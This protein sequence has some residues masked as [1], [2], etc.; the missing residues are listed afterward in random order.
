MKKLFCLLLLLL[1]SFLLPG[2]ASYK[3]YKVL[4]SIKKEIPNDNF[5]FVER[6][7]LR[8]NIFDGSSY[9]GIIYS[10]ALKKEKSTSGITVWANTQGVDFKKSYRHKLSSLKNGNIIKDK[11]K[12][13]FQNPLNTTVSGSSISIDIFVDDLANVDIDEIKVKGAKLH[14][15]VL[16]E[17][18][19]NS[20]I[21]ISIQNQK[22]I[23]Y[24]VIKDSISIFFRNDKKL[25][26]I[27]NK[28]KK[29]RI[30][31]SDDE[32]RYLANSFYGSYDE[33]S[34][35]D[36]SLNRRHYRKNKSSLVSMTISAET[37][38]EYKLWIRGHQFNKNHEI[39][40]HF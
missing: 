38:P 36:D 28:Y 4:S 23:T 5:Y 33:E 20:Y 30:S 3:G 26:K 8:F 32:W 19:I 9:R 18:N 14:K 21:Y 40:D 7:S 22:D 34:Y 1:I 6:L 16:D 11:V 13:I 25:K 31:L 35:G 39:V 10:D 27:S 29:N 17:S 24:A 2:C 37:T 12:E 15:Y